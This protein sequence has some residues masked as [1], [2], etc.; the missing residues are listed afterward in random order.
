MDL[1]TGTST[2]FKMT[3]EVASY[4]ANNLELFNCQTGLVH[5]HH[6]MGAFFSSTDL[7]TLQAEGNTTNCFV[8]LVVDTKGTYVAA[9]T[10]KVKTKRK[11]T[12]EDSSVSY[13]F[14]GEGSKETS[15]GNNITR[16]AE[17]EEIQYFMLDVERHEVDNHL[18]FL[19]QR[20]EEIVNKKMPPKTA[21]T[22]H[23]SSYNPILSD[24]WNFPW[25]KKQKE[26][27]QKESSLFD[28]EETSVSTFSNSNDNLEEYEVEYIP[29]AKLIHTAVCRMVMCSLLF[30]TDKYDLKQWIKRHMQNVYQRTFSD[31]QSFQE[32]ADFAVSF[33]VYNFLDYNAPSNL[34]DVQYFNCIIEAMIAE[35][36]PFADDKLPYIQTYITTLE[37]NIN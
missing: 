29:D 34:P 5:S 19:D 6:Q 10:R 21:P 27:P 17:V 12:V 37:N 35:L 25:D 31:E 4:V 8:S 20:F 2:E 33:F 15:K 22:T 32:W 1:G 24:N 30:N 26:A 3:P 18:A 7:A 23:F 14:F 16:E 28:T 36:A 11:V 13:T 9:I